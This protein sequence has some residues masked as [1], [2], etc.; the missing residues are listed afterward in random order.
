MGV[1]GEDPSGAAGWLRELEVIEQFG[2]PLRIAQKQPSQHRL[3]SR[4]LPIKGRISTPRAATGPVATA[5]HQS[6]L[7]RPEAGFQ[8]LEGFS[9]GRSPHPRDHRPMQIKGPGG[10]AAVDQALM[11]LPDRIPQPGE[12]L[13][14]EFDG[15]G[16]TGQAGQPGGRRIRRRRGCQAPAQDRAED[17]EIAR[18]APASRSG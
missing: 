14:R 6:Q 13:G 15:G 17:A 5:P 8:A 1:V 7:L 2:K 3:K 18:G 16:G 9:L 12:L 10:L 4:G 11:Q